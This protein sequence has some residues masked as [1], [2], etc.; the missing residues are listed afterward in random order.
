MSDL[1]E[2]RAVQGTGDPQEA[3]LVERA[4]RGD[5]DA[6][7]EIVRRH[8]QQV[9]AVAVRMLGSVDDAEDVA[10]DAFIRAFRAIS[11][12]RAEAKVSTW[13]V[14]I[15]MNLCRNRRR[16]WLRRRR[17][18]VA[19][20]DEPVER[21]AG[22]TTLDVADPAL[23]PDA[24]AERREAH[25][26]L[27]AAMQLLD[28]PSRAVLVL[29]DV[30]GYSYEEIAEILGCRIGT[31]KSRLSRARLALRAVLNGRF[32]TGWMP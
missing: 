11:S 13:L 9:F 4:Q 24:L 6:F 25:Q 10:Q 26:R 5:L 2:G 15:T 31:V 7:D 1:S 20:L 14:A 8:Q 28:E 16:W 3:A 22:S 30:Q 19:S 23:G 12:F 21:E 17:M 29:R 32:G 27:L 18:I